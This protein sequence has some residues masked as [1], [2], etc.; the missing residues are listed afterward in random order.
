MFIYPKPKS[1]PTCSCRVKEECPLKQGCNVSSVI[2]EAELT[3]HCENHRNTSERYVGMVQKEFK[4]R[5]YAHNASFRHEGKK[6]ETTLASRVWEYKNQGIPYRINW[7]ILDNPTPYRNGSRRCALCTTEKL[8]I[9]QGLTSK[10]KYLN[11]KSEIFRSCPHK[12]RY[13][14]YAWREDQTTRNKPP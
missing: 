12:K 4:Q 11:T 3:T 10:Y 6:N 7:S 13:L 2:Y 5:F 1:T 14:L 9:L 8:R